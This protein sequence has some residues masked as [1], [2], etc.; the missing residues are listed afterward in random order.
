M[1]RLLKGKSFNPNPSQQKVNIIGS[2][3]VGLILAYYLNKQGYEVKIY[4]R[5][6]DPL[7]NSNFDFSPI[8]TS[9]GGRDARHISATETLPQ[10]IYS[11]KDILKRSPKEGGWLLLEQ[12]NSIEQNWVND[13]KKN[14]LNL[15]LQKT[16]TDF[17]IKLNKVAIKLWQ[18]PEFGIDKFL[19]QALI[20][21]KILKIY[22]DESVRADDL[23]LQQLAFLNKAEITQLERE[24]ILEKFPWLKEQGIIKGIEVP[25]WSLNL[26]VFLENLKKYLKESG[27]KIHFNQEIKDP[28]LLKG[29]T[30]NTSSYSDRIQ[31]SI[32]CWLTLPNDIGLKEGFKIHEKDPLGALN[33]TPSF[34]RKEFYFAGG[35]GFIGNQTPNMKDKKVQELFSLLKKAAK[36]YFPQ[37]YK[38]AESNNNLQEKY[39]IRPMTTDGLPFIEVLTDSYIHVGGTNCGGLV[40]APILAA[41][42]FDLLTY[43]FF[44]SFN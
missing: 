5:C 7:D 12:L 18:N 24:Q 3:I 8:S 38:I 13:F 34:D 11:R 29:L 32:G 42:T 39:C 31:G 4:D 20:G 26:H 15:E 9:Y 1:H 16:N 40:Q 6:P 33:I 17:I 10:A 22:F 43:G 27:I 25:G 14:S 21:D 28:D 2:G 36:N 41:L 44:K 23:K 37:Q 19:A 35:F 30:I